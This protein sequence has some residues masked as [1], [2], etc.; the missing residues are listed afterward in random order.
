VLKTR[1]IAVILHRGH[2][3]VKGK[4]F[5]SWRPV[6]S[7]LNVARVHARRGVDEIILLDIGATPERR[8]PDFELIK[9]VSAEIMSPLTIGGGIT[10]VEHFREALRCGADKVA[11]RSAVFR[12]IELIDRAAQRFGR[13]A[14]TVAL[15][16]V[17]ARGPGPEFAGLGGLIV[18]DVRRGGVGGDFVLAQNFSGPLDSGRIETSPFLPRE[19]AVQFAKLCEAHGAGELLVTSVSRDGCL[20]GYDIELIRDVAN[21]VSIPVVANG[22]AGSYADLAAGIRSGA[23]AVAAGALWQFTDATPAEAADYLF[24][25]GHAVRRDFIEPDGVIGAARSAAAQKLNVAV[26]QA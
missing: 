8:D 9:A 11:V 1:V 22:G 15:D 25:Q 19:S 20:C 16:V 13:Q 10:S 14:V 21:A 17:E 23:H 26:A 5:D 3:A 18:P 24:S 4:R 7:V 6:G 2:Q 12:D